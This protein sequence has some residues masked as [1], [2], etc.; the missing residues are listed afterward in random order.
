MTGIVVAGMH[1]SGTSLMAR[2]LADGGYH[3]GNEL[4]A[5]PT[6]DYF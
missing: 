2:M 1:R 3:P 5:R 4:L 6:V